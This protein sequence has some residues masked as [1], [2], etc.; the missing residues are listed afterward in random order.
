MHYHFMGINGSGVSG[1]AQLAYDAGHQVSGCDARL[2][3]YAQSLS[4]RGV[5]LFEGHSPDHLDGVDGIIFSGAIPL[6]NPELI[7]AKEQGITLFHR[8]EFLV[9]LLSSHSV[10][11]VTGTHGKTTTTWM[12]FHLFSQSGYN[13]TCYAGGKYRGE[14][15]H[16]GKEP[17]I[18]ELDES[19]GSV[20]LS[21]PQHLLITNLEPEH[22]DYYDNDDELLRRFEKYIYKL[23]PQSLI[24]GRG[25]LFSNQLQELY[26]TTTLPSLDDIQKK[27]SLTNANGMD[28][29]H[30]KWYWYLSYENREYLV[31]EETE[32][33]FVLQNRMS[34]MITWL[35]WIVSSN[36]VLPASGAISWNSFGTISRRFETIGERDGIVL[37]DDYAHH[38]TEL[39]A[40]ISAAERQYRNFGI[41]FQAHRYSRFE[42]FFDDFFEVLR[43]SEPLFILPVFSAGE[44]DQNSDKSSEVLWKMLKEEGVD[45][46]YLPTL[47][48][49]AL[50]FKEQLPSLRIKALVSTGAGDGNTVLHRLC[51]EI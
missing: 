14:M 6:D 16:S 40:T 4:K 44:Q 17:W 27:M 29:I 10:I 18:V 32:P 23:A 12:L 41:L 7:A 20:F 31:G 2:G 28:F 39:A 15:A 13:P 35:S 30:K 21:S 43:M 46:Y 47:D 45:A 22:V 3:S 9:E 19:D 24:I 50:F 36:D 33:P 51:D 1:L 5:T 48:A 49:A 42:R 37:V 26:S 25:Y 11:G 38:P 34:A 8:A